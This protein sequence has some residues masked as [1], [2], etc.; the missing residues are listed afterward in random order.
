M[1][2]RNKP[3]DRILIPERPL[4]IGG[5]RIYGILG[6]QEDENSSAYTL[7]EYF[8]WLAGLEQWT[9]NGGTYESKGDVWVHSDE[10]H[11]YLDNHTFRRVVMMLC[12]GLVGYRTLRFDKP[13]KTKKGE[14]DHCWVIDPALIERIEEKE[15]R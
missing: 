5:L 11:S 8:T 10:I 14:T 7:E 13:I 1:K 15:T 3:Y 6:R 4:R 12:T 2:K 9:R